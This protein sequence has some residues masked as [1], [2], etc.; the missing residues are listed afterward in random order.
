M[1]RI[2]KKV[3]LT[4][5]QHQ[6]LL[7][8]ATSRT[9]RQDHIERAN[10]ILKCVS[11]SNSKISC[12]LNISRNTAKKWRKRWEKNEEKLLLIDKEE[13]GIFYTRKLLEI[14]SDEQRAGAP[15]KFTAEQICQIMSVACERPEDSGLP[16]SHW[17]L[18]S[19]V[20]EVIKREIVESIS[21]S[22]LAVFLKSGRHKT[23]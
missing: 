16:I 3:T 12:E 10:I 7:Q 9:Q 2:A 22:R 15:C 4:D 18:D 13:N 1:P 19:L 21:R 17:S 11:E 20:D 14:L 23:P 8:I 6:T 5:K